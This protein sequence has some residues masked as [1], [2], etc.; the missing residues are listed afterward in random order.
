MTREELANA[1]ENGNYTDACFAP[2]SKNDVQVKIGTEFINIDK[3]GNAYYCISTPISAA[4]L[5]KA[6]KAALEV[7]I[8]AGKEH[9][10]DLEAKLAE[11][12]ES[13]ESES[14]NK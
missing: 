11:L 2:Y 13:N 9:V 1:I 3:N 14:E 5:K 10:A 8:K 4:A 6:R 12:N 7:A